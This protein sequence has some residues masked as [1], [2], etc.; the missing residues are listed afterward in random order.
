M[1]SVRTQPV[2]KMAEVKTLTLK[3]HVLNI[4]RLVIKE[5]R[6]IR[7]DPTM[8]VLVVY[9]FTISVN[10]VATG[11]VTEATNLSVGIVDEDGSD[12][13]RQLAEGLVRPTF[14]PPVHITASQIDQKMDRGELLFVVEIPPNFQANIL[15]KRKT[16]L[17]IDVDATAVAQAGNGANYLKTALSN[18]VQN[19][20]A[21]RQGSGSRAPINL[22]TRA[23]FN[24]NLKTAWFSAMTQVINQIT[25]LTVILTGAALIR[26]REQGTVEHLLVMPVVPAEIMLAKML[27]NGL[28]I[29]VAA[30]FSLQFVVHLW[31]GAPIAGSIVL[32]LFGAALYALVVA[33]LGILLGTLSTTMGQFGLLAMPVLMITQL[34]SG[35]STPMESMPVWLQYVMK[36]ISP[37]PHFVAFAQAVLFRGADLMLVWQ[38]LLAMLIIGSIYFVIAMSRFRRVI[39][40]S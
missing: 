1:A 4:F 20:L 24:P 12:L 15:T 35:S 22:V 19:F 39:F 21:G 40:G 8:L 5:L 37:T 34:L 16:E 29:L 7:S 2:P 27:A 23:S 11:A 26:E 9:A 31:I 17:Q 25:L 32:F 13:S 36:T 14:Q 3:D 10:T 30:M 33:A 38:P 6:S 18:E 28:V